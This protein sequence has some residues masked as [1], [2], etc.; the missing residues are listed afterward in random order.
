VPLLASLQLS[1]VDQLHLGSQHSVSQDSRKL[2]VPSLH[3]VNLPL[4]S[5]LLQQP[6]PSVRPRVHLLSHRFRPSLLQA[7]AHPLDPRHSD[8]HLLSSSL[9]QRAA[10]VNQLRHSHSLARPHHRLA[11]SHS[12]H[13][14]KHQRLLHLDNHL[15][16]PIP[17]ELPLHSNSPPPRH[18]VSLPLRRVYLFSRL[19]LDLVRSS[20]SMILMT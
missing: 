10:L 14:S 9:Q 8:S 16:H 12:S 3:S 11:K 13:S 2:E 17:S 19:M 4:V 1:V 6:V 5:P 7:S 15:R 20:K 18:L